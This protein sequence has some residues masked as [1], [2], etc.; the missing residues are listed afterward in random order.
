LLARLPS[1]AGPPAA[2]RVLVD[3][4]Y[5]NPNYWIRYAFLRAALG[6][7]R[8]REVAVLGPYRA[9]DCRRTLGRLGAAG[10]VDVG[11]LAGPRAAHRAGAER[12]LA[13]TRTADDI[14]KWRLPADFPADFVY[15][16]L[17]KRQRAAVV[18]LDD[19]RLPRWVA[20]ALAS[21][22]ASERALDT[23]RP[24]LV[25]LS[26]A[27]NFQFGSLAW[28][29][30]RRGIPTVL[31]QGVYGVSRFVKLLQPEHL[32]ETIDRPAA[33]DLARL[34]RARAERLA[35][36]GRAYLEA[37]W[38]GR[39]D[40]LGALYAFRR[41]TETPTRERLA[42]R[43]GWDAE[44]P[45]VAVYASNWFD[46]PHPCGMTQFRDF[47]DWM[48]ATLDAAVD[49]RR[50]NWLFKAHPCDAWYGGVTLSDLVPPL[51]THPHL[52]LVPVEWNGAAL[53]RA[54]DALVTVHGT[55]GVEFA[56]AGKPVLVADRGWYHDAGFVRWSRSRA[57]YVEALATDWWK[58]LDVEAT[59]RHAQVFAGWYFARPA[60][61]DGLV[62]EDDP[63]QGEIYRTAP[64]LL[65]EHPQ[66]LARELDTIREWFASPHRHYHTY[67]MSVADEFAF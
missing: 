37:R 33:T 26:H 60:W 34:S 11:A 20:D 18:E 44:R 50:V 32:Y 65:T 3:A 21:I 22:A 6:L 67:K 10:A 57:E 27:V 48:R 13:D 36:A 19:P 1:P 46:F 43:F 62:M 28:L 9:R 45:I 29:A 25:V 35:A 58:D 17:L 53:L 8:A 7:S 47:L 66:A 38:S 16:G 5:D 42:A 24:D 56:A 59:T 39:T 12:L 55:A 52:R 31:A 2:V 30:A 40:D 61:Q 49:N 63:R 54:V 15:D 23:T 4:M 41:A 14:L 64:R 51:D